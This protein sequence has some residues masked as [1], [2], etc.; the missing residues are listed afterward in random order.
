LPGRER[1]RVGQVREEAHPKHFR[2]GAGDGGGGQEQASGE[3]DG[4]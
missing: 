4:E 2:F 1:R 3:E